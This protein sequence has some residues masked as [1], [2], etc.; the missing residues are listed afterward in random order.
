MAEPFSVR[1]TSEAWRAD[2][3]EWVHD[4]VAEHGHSV[5]G[6][7]DQRRVAPWSTQI[8]VPSDAGTLWFKA[9]C[10][11]MSFEPALQELLARLAP[12]DVDRPYA[13]DARRGWMI[14]SD[15]GATLGDS[16]EPSLDDWRAVVITAADLQRHVAAHRDE[17]LVTGV[18]D[19]SPRTVPG[20]LEE[21][22]ERF[23]ELP[24]DHPS[25]I[26][27]DLHLDLLAIIPRVVDACEQIEATPMPMTVQH[28]DLHPWNVFAAGEPGR[29]SLRIFD[30]GDVQW[31]A[32]VEVLSVP[33][34][35][36]AEEG[37]LEWEPIREAYSERWSDVVNGRSL[38]ALWEAT[39]FTQPVNRAQTWADCLDGV[40]DQE[41]ADWGTAPLHHLRRVLEA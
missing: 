32:A 13:I 20:R 24:S 34:G 31:A 14:T 11:S 28:G 29:Q 38:D 22:A 7:L 19:C 30:F 9:L 3:E 40:T 2:V 37:R 35:F 23:A 8:V 26:D 10:P 15:R 5:T 36:L 17:V 21:L 12:D 39:A 16:H 1:V 41:L 25:H 4:R 6:T 27:T 18:V 33:F